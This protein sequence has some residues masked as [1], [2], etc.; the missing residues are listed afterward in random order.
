ML[1]RSFDLISP[2]ARDECVRRLREKTES[3]WYARFVS[4]KPVVG[5]VEK[6]S[7][8]I[9]KRIAYRN[10]FPASVERGAS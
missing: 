1:S 8:R 9:F 4:N 3:D 2:L 6:T 7:F 5:R 10:S